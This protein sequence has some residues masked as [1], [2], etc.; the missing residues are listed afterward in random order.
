MCIFIQKVSTQ[1]I[2]VK[3]LVAESVSHGRYSR[4]NDFKT[5][6][7]KIAIVFKTILKQCFNHH[8]GLSG[9]AFTSFAM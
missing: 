9:I 7:V 2:D 4:L 3:Y 5:F 1:H 6:E 8:F